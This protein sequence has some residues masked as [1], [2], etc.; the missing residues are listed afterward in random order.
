MRRSLGSE[1]SEKVVCVCGGEDWIRRGECPTDGG[2]GEGSFLLSVVK[3]R[4]R[5]C[6]RGPP[7]ENK[8]GSTLLLPNR[9]TFV[10]FEDS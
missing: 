5:A 6:R 2:T 4:E 8:S 3:R 10:L 1:G 9:E 7:C